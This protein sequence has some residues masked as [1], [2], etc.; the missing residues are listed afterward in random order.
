MAQADGLQPGKQATLLLIEQAIK[1]QNG[2]F[3]FMRR[4]L[5]GRGM[6][7]HRN[8]LMAAPCEGLFAAR[9]GIDRSIEKLV[10]YLDAGQMLLCDQ[11]P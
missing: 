4:G 6:N 9:D 10:I 7:R 5:E 11:M 1:E 3:E 2:G 8:N